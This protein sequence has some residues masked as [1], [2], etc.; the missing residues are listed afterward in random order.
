MDKNCLSPP[1]SS[2][3][4]L[5]LLLCAQAGLTTAPEAGAEIWQQGKTTRATNGPETLS[6]RVEMMDA[7]CSIFLWLS[8][9][10]S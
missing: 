10:S 3:S 2:G 5:T 4:L 1:G 7:E 6:Q 9:K 8:T